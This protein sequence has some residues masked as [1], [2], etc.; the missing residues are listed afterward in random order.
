MP[1]DDF[2]ESTK[3]I[4]AERAGYICSNPDCESPTI[5]ATIGKTDIST[6]TGEAAHICAASAGGAR[7]VARMTSEQRKS[8]SNGIWLCASCATLIDKNDGI[9]YSVDLLNDW[10]CNRESCSSSALQGQL[11]RFQRMQERIEGLQSGGD[12]FCYAMLYNFDLAKD[13]ARQFV[14]IREGEYPLYDLRIRLV[15][16]SSNH[17][18]FE[19]AWGELNG[20]A[21]FELVEWSLPQDVYYR[22]FFHARNGD[23]HQDL[24]LKKSTHA[25]CWLAS[26][27]VSDRKGNPRFTKE[28]NEFSCE[29]G[30][31]LWRP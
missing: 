25:G 11:N 5:G 18:V 28:D 8:P 2:S 30:S 12:T 26:T 14:I 21:Q 17:T 13:C 19:R 23:W 3:R 31:P 29:F 7:Y 10:K 4:I 9:N 22:F 16:M 27:R 20:P 15:E 6:K 24:I 1:R